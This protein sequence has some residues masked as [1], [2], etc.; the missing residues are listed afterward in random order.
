MAA[1]TDTD[2]ER[3]AV[4]GGLQVT[5]SFG[6]RYPTNGE[7]GQRRAESARRVGLRLE[8]GYFGYG[9]YY[10]VGQLK[11]EIMPGSARYELVV[12]EGM[13]TTKLSFDEGMMLVERARSWSD[14]RR[15]SEKTTYI[16]DQAGRLRE[17]RETAYVTGVGDK[18]IS[19]RICEYDHGVGRPDLDGNYLMRTW[20]VGREYYHLSSQPLEVKRYEDGQE[21]K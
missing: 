3:A 14:P 19:R 9:S 12:A 15:P 11:P 13:M 7:T 10:T 6:K 1:G 4:L 5:P 16:Y 21:K 18:V 17:E 8:G 20:P 2:R